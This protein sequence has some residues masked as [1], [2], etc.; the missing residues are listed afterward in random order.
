MKTRWFSSVD[1]RGALSGGRGADR[2]KLLRT[3]Y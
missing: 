1:V 2:D 3:S